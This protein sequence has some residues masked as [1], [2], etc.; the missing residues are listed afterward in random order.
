MSVNNSKGGHNESDV[1]GGMVTGIIRRVIGE[2]IKTTTPSLTSPQ[3][4]LK[5]TNEL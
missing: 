4:N 2:T 3:T 5:E 1:K